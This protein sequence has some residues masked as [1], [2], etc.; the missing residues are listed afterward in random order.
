[1]GPV[2]AGAAWLTLSRPLWLAAGGIALLPVLAA[3]WGARRHRRTPPTAVVVQCLA[4][5]VL[6]V[7]LARP[8]AAL[9]AR[10]A[11]PFL[12]LTDASG[13]VRG[14]LETNWPDLPGGAAAETF[15]FADGL[16]RTRPASGAATDVA[17]ALRLI[18]SYAA[19]APPAAILATDGRFTEPLWEGPARS[20]A[21]AG[22]DVF[23]VPMNRPPPDARIAALAAGRA[24][25]RVEI[26][27]TVVA[28]AP[29]ARRLTVR[30]AG[31]DT[32]L[33]DRKLS[34]LPNAPAT[35]RLDDA[36]AAD[37]AAEYTAHVGEGDPIPEN[38]SASVVVL[39]QRRRV[40][41]VGFDLPARRLLGPLGE[42]VRFLAPAELPAKA[43]ELAALGAV[44]VLDA[45]GSAFSPEQRRALA[46]S[47]RAGRGLVVI[48]TG[49]HATPADRDDGLNQ[50]LPLVPD[51]FRRRPLH[52]LVLLDRSG[53]MAQ[54][55]AARLGGAVQKKFDLA[56][57]AAV[58]LKD[59]LTPRDALTVIAFAD[60]PEVI[61]DSGNRPPDP[62]E[63]R[64]ALQRVRPAGNTNVTP[65][66]AEAL[67]RP[68]DAGRRRMLLVVS[69]LETEDFDPAEWARKLRQAK[70]HLAVVAIGSRSA[71]APPLETLT[72]LLKPDGAAYVRRDHLAGLAKVFAALVRNGRGPITVREPTALTV[73][74]GLFGTRLTALPNADS[75]ILTGAKRQAEVLASTAGGEPVL[76][77][78]AA[79]VGRTV[80][81]ALPIGAGANAA[82]RDAPEA[83]ALLS[84]AVRWTAPHANDP[85]FDARLT[86]RGERLAVAVSARDRGR[87]VN[88]LALRA[89]VWTGRSAEVA[90][91]RQVAPGRYEGAAAC[92]SADPAAVVVRDEKGAMLWQGSA[93]AMYPAEYRFLGLDDQALRRLAELTGGKI[94]PASALA[95]QLA[96]ARARRLTDLWP[97]LLG[98]ALALALGEWCLVRITRR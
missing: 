97:A 22:L 6:V 53:S 81:L 75:Y 7:A 79:G 46:E 38:D 24:A 47:V 20:V 30:R 32:P 78:R 31:L 76:A 94:V 51:P 50:V 35:F 98:A 9:T 55:A 96:G 26:A 29:L 95:R 91:L 17:A 66:V 3:W 61:Y 52:L 37:A 2:I 34:L 58:A 25:G 39:P 60:R 4:L 71:P 10:A 83:A 64:K 77:R 72:T 70:A 23:L 36:V 56:A 8:R 84:A 5:A 85:R 54:D 19:K 49:P 14:Q 90:E 69:D 82:W 87:A 15:Y 33:L 1:M 18:A 89:H 12:V 27:V 93:A 73:K 92:P 21:A 59:H 11:R 40:A 41:A 63:L 45:T 88:G 67:S 80:M 62:A 44:V 65:A 74:A 86:R 57:E 28:N 48:G 13:S 43:A 16:A 42:Q 68:P